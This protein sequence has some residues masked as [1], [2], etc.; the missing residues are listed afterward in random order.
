M[1]NLNE[2]RTDTMSDNGHGNRIGQE[3]SPARTTNGAKPKSSVEV[4]R[5]ARILPFA[6]DERS[7]AEAQIV[8]N[9]VG[10]SLTS[11]ELT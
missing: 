1:A 6:V 7:R 4:Y 5:L 10:E 2:G 9:R 3:V 11:V 8:A